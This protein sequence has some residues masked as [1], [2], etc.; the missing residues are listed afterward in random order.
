LNLCECVFYVL[1]LLLK[2]VLAPSFIDDDAV[3]Y[4]RHHLKE[5]I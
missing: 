3:F 1:V 5:L 2:K 4:L